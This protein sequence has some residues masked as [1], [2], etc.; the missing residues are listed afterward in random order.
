MIAEGAAHT[1]SM[2]QYMLRMLIW[3]VIS[4]IP[5]SLMMGGVMFTPIH[6]NVMWTLIIL[7]AIALLEKVKKRF[8]KRL[9]K[10]LLSIPIVLT[11]ALIGI[12]AMVDYFG[13]GV[14]MVLVY[15]INVEVLGGLYYDLTIFGHTFEIVQQGLALFALIPVWLYNGERGITAKPFKYFCYAFYPAHLICLFAIRT[16][17]LG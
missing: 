13:A 16:I 17:M 12:V 4:E 3:A 8:K 1:H 14:L 2:G 6:Q 7:I 5:F 10:V 9:I 15:V 11:A